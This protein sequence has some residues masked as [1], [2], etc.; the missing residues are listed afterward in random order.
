MAV[1][2][3]V[4]DGDVCFVLRLCETSTRAKNMPGN[5]HPTKMLTHFFFLNQTDSSGRQFTVGEQNVLRSV[6]PE[7]GQHQVADGRVGPHGTARGATPVITATIPFARRAGAIA[8]DRNTASNS[9]PSRCTVVA[10]T[11]IIGIIAV[12]RDN[13]SNT[14]NA[15][16]SC[17]SS[18][19]VCPHIRR[20]VAFG[21][22][23]DE[24]HIGRS[25][26]N[27]MHCAAQDHDL[28][29]GRHD[30][31]VVSAQAAAAVAHASTIAAPAAQRRYNASRRR[32]RTSCSNGQRIRC[33]GTVSA[34][35]TFAASTAAA[36]RQHSHADGHDDIDEC[37]HQPPTKQPR[38]AVAN[39][40]ADAGGS[41]SDCVTQRP[42]EEAAAA[43]SLSSI[44]VQ[45]PTSECALLSALC[46][47]VVHIHS[48]I[49]C[50]IERIHTHS[51]DKQH[52]ATLY[53]TNTPRKYQYDFFM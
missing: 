5:V 4:A 36:E 51:H 11:I 41:L 38:V 50:I 24:P 17:P 43:A 22:R 34:A 19:N 39:N 42:E 35:T 1:Y 29:C 14:A 33:A 52:H 16:D 44:E 53:H 6:R 7:L 10:S 20:A 47:H 27:H 21:L 46:V 49:K 9:A 2:I 15:F 8:R 30:S 23:L 13:P 45:L 12:R 18:H 26:C 32:K 40:D 3:Y 25:Q 37:Q 48:R 31:A 28:D